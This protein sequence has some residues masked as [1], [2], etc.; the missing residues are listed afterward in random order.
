MAGR[1]GALIC[2]SQQNEKT[3]IVAFFIAKRL[4][5]FDVLPRGSTFNQLYFINNTFPD[6]KTANLN[7]RRQKTGSAMW[8]HMDNFMRH[9]YV[10]PCDF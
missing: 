3:M 4:I 1:G 7:F 8:V 9:L 6:L 5:V 2:G 10:N